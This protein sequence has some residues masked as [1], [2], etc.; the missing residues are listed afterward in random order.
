MA[1]AC[2][3]V[4]AACFRGTIPARQ[5]YR[6]V[7][8]DT[9]SAPAAAIAPPLA[10]SLAVL[11]YS[12]PGVYGQTNI[13]YRTDSVEYGAYPSREWAVP[14]GVMLGDLTEHVLRA[15]PLTREPAVYDP[16]SRREHSYVWR[17]RVRE[18]DEVDA[19]GVVHAVVSL[20]ATLS[21]A[22][23]D[24][25]LWTGGIRR[26]RIVPQPTMSAIVRTLSDL[27][28]ESVQALVD[29]AAA[30]VRAGPATVAR[31]PR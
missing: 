26:D 16:P 9:I 31:P 1:L 27:S 7:P 14:L 30:A 11:P 6:L 2:V 10:G 28:N 24:S 5:L 19:G 4:S 21:R 17:G 12:S 25:L 13:V 3:L 8:L 15:R 18:F 20:D 29:Q 23:D 22:L